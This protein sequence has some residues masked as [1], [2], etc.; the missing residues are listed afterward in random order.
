MPFCRALPILALALLAACQSAEERA[1]SHYQEALRLISANDPVRAKLELRNVFDLDGFHRDARAAYAKLL[2]ADGD[3][4]GAYG[5]YL[6]LVEQYPDDVEARRA[7]ALIAV[8]GRNWDEVRRHSEA[9]LQLAPEDPGL[10]A[11]AAALAYRDA[12]EAEDDAAGAKAAQAAGAALADDPSVTA[13]RLVMIDRIMREGRPEAALALVDDGLALRSDEPQLRRLRIGILAQMDDQEKLGEELAASARL[14]PE[15]RQIAE[16]YLRLLLSQGDQDGAEAFL[17]ERIDA[18]DPA[19]EDR[20]PLLQFLRQVRGPEAL[21]TELDTLLAR[22]DVPDRALLRAMRAGLDFETGRTE[23]GVE[24]MTALLDEADSESGPEALGPVERARLHVTLARMRL[25]TGDRVGARA[26]VENALGIDPASAEAYKLRASW[27]ISDDDPDAAIT[28]LRAALSASPRDPEIMTM[29]AQA[30][31]LNGNQDLAGEMLARAVELSGSAP[32]E[33][34]R[35]AEFLA[36]RGRADAA[37]GVV[38]DALRLAP[39]DLR[40]L[41]ASGRMRLSEKDWVRLDEVVER[42]NA[43]P[44]GQGRAAA[45]S[46]RAS[47]LAAQERTDEL[48][49][50]LTD[51]AGEAGEVGTGAQAA[52]VRTDLAA[53]RLEEAVARARAIAEADP[54]KAGPHLLLGA[55]LAAAG[56]PDEAKTEL[57]AA[58]E[59]EPTLER[60]WVA[61]IRL[62]AASESPEA[63]AALAAEAAEAAP[64]S[65]EIQWMQAS[66][67]EQS[68]DFAGAI[69]VY[70]SIY[71]RDRNSVVVANNLASLLATTSTDAETLARAERISRRLRGTDVPAF[72]DTYG[73]LAFLTG[74]TEEALQYLAPAAEG[75]PEDP[76]VRF[77]LASA[78]A[79][80]GLPEAA[81]TL[82]EA[83]RIAEEQEAAGTNPAAAALLDKITR[84]ELEM[85]SGQ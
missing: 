37:A 71:D 10:R 56:Q 35:Y 8:D 85:P 72:Q 5:H 31:V 26:S 24:A 58:V 25:A 4:S 69:A 73:W 17:R 79:K 40:L 20:L 13:A 82:A 60:A 34:L 32:E 16:T 48:E 7:L 33:S 63:V 28:A 55:A 43:L 75:L 44:E 64:G 66:T 14:F 77:H 80:A 9:G 18:E 19:W 36:N 1:E 27:A 62:A 21:R 30:H 38:A 67:L 41:E 61:L 81:E 70:E 45:E 59:R 42:L 47:A 74:N 2:I 46:F 11:A 51:L 83:R 12:L 3:Y 76:Q 23:A 15:D 39:S 29:M 53:G 22:E 52:L 84:L 57:R 68:G 65:T 54:D 49:G 50:L 78:Q 6:R